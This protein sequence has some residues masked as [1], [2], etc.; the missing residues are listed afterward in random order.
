MQGG[1]DGKPRKHHIV[2]HGRAYHQMLYTLLTNVPMQ[3]N[4]WHQ[5]LLVPQAW[6]NF[7]NRCFISYMDVSIGAFSNICNF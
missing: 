4:D 5:N 6:G 1:R 7:M 3:P 2:Q